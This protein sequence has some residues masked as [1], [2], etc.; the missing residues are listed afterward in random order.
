MFVKI[1]FQPDDDETDSALYECRSVHFSRT[2]EQFILNMDLP[3]ER[4]IDL[5][6][7]GRVYALNNNGRTIDSHT[8]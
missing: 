4:R 8:I 1:V 5:Q 7:H 6:Q 3:D 2:G